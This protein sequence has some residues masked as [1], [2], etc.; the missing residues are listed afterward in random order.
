MT[1]RR[2]MSLSTLAAVL[3]A[4]GGLTV[5]GSGEKPAEKPAAPAAPAK[6]EPPTPV[7]DPLEGG[8]YPA[9]VLSQAWFWK[10][11]A[12][13]P[14]PG[15][16]R[17]EIWRET[18]DGWKKSRLEDPDSNVFHKAIFYDGGL[19]TIGG[20]KAMLKKWT[21]AD[22]AWKQETL[23]QKEFGGKFNRLRDLEVG[24]V[25]GDGKDEL[26]IA[27]HDAGVI[28][29]YNPDDPTNVIELDRAPDTFVHEIEI[30]DL[31][32]D[33]KLEF[34]AT[35]SGRNTAAGSQS[36]A[37]VL[38]RWD[39]TTYQRT[40]VE[41]YGA[42]HAKEALIADVDGDGKAELFG[43]LE[44]EKSKEAVKQPVI[45]RQYL[46]KKDGTF[47][48]K[49]IATIDDHQTRFLVPADIDQDGQVELIASA[50]KSGVWVLER[51]A[52]GAWTSTNI[53][54]QSSGFEHST[55]VTDLNGDGK[56][57][58]YVA[59][60]DQAELKRYVYN[61]ETKLYESTLIGKLSD[62]TFTWN[63]AAGRL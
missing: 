30:G 16:A 54:R 52:D 29:V 17:L 43:V 3:L 33:G 41:Q 6:V 1:K 55:F 24:D 45:I 53:D 23:W 14:K 13:K 56:P 5:C 28:A 22:G 40:V 58:M 25:D 46:P 49:D 31:D 35:P 59:A 60:D 36:G 9:V 62:S 47:T 44:A 50:M 61:P 57:E 34:A 10:D 63:L 20:E 11:E 19:L 12:G 37:L 51:G 2:L 42:T 18:A 39:G 7:Q 38:Y 15:P 4:L 26:V 48:S 8:P 27:T 32:G 21:F